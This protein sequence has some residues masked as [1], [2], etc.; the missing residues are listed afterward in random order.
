MPQVVTLGDINVDIIASLLRYP[1]PGGDGLA[2]RVEVHSGGSAANTATV[3]A[4]FGVDVGIIGRVGRDAFAEQA[5][6][7]LAKAGVDLRCIQRDDEVITGMMFIPVTP[8]GERTMFGYR[9]ANTRLDPALLDEGYIAQADVFHLSG[10]ALL[11]EPQRSAARR[12]MEMAHRAG[13]AI[14]L[15]TGLEAAARATEEVKAL[16]P[17]VDLIFPNRA[18]AEHLTG[19]SE[20]KEAV[21]ALSGYGIETVA[22]KLGEQGCTVG[23]EGAIFSVP[24][25]AVEVQDTTGAGDSFDAGFILGRLW[26]LDARQSAILANALGALAASAVGA[27]DALPGPGEAQALLQGCLSDPAWRD[28]ERGIGRILEYLSCCIGR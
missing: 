2:E 7:R 25:F 20:V 21:K 14:S 23:S 3:L 1:P 8:D 10:Y 11:S 5:L 22:L 24:A 19:S 17:L 28:W 18:E 26:D 15:D 12:A 13:V 6:A 4:N 16:L 27:G 9:G